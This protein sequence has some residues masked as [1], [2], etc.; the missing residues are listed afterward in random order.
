MN[1]FND[2]VKPSTLEGAD[3]SCKGWEI[4]GS[5]GY[6]PKPDFQ[7]KSGGSRICEN[8]FAGSTL[9]GADSTG[10]QSQTY[11][12]IKASKY[13][14]KMTFIPDCGDDIFDFTNCFGGISF[15]EETKLKQI[16]SFTEA[17]TLQLD[18]FFILLFTINDYYYYIQNNTIMLA[19]ENINIFDDI[20]S[21]LRDVFNNNEFFSTII[22]YVFCNLD[23][24]NNFADSTYFCTKMIESFTSSINYSKITGRNDE[25]ENYH[26]YKSTILSFFTTNHIKLGEYLINIYNEL[27]TDFD[28]L[29]I[30]ADDILD[31][32]TKDELQSDDIIKLES[33]MHE[34]NKY[35]PN[36][37][38]DE[39]LQSYYE[40]YY[41]R[42]DHYDNDDNNDNNDDNNDFN[43]YQNGTIF[44]YNMQNIITMANKK[45]DAIGYE[46]YYNGSNKWSHALEDC[47]IEHGYADDSKEITKIIYYVLITERDTIGYLNNHD[48]MTLYDR[49]TL[50][51]IAND[52]YTSY[53]TFVDKLGQNFVMPYDYPVEIIIQILCRYY[54]INI[55][56]Y[57]EN[58]SV[59]EFNNSSN[60]TN[61]NI[62]R[63]TFDS[64]YNI[65]PIGQTF[66]KS[67]IK[68]ILLPSMINF[69]SNNYVNTNFK[70][71]IIVND[72][73]DITEI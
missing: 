12:N 11:K 5:T 14:S 43:T 9:E 2:E 47:L 42:G 39:I 19:H 7:R 6:T 24:E 1:Q 66:V 73:N 25:D 60:I 68:K 67:C 56:L 48:D 65:L 30:F 13:F 70:S 62:Y 46:I 29:I 72:K 63:Y 69:E 45:L 34:N 8:D 53:D 58:L 38:N 33:F 3:S 44:N 31:L 15:M 22:P 40:F 17:T 23:R 71:D 52:M 35:L 32:C 16:C 27:K 54:N 20:P 26:N 61:I 49:F 55:T 18:A 50:V 64:Y 4:S 37:D 36:F 21:E 41:S 59:I 51:S 10:N 28:N 57:S